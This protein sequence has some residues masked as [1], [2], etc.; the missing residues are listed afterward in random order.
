MSRLKFTKRTLLALPTPAEKRTFHYDTATPG[1]ALQI[2]PKGARTFYLCR[3]VNGR[4]QRL[5]L[6]TFPAVTV[7]QA[8]RLALEALGEIADGKDPHQQRLAARA[9]WTLQDLFDDYLARHAKP[10]K[11][12]WRE[13]ERQFR[14]Y[15]AQWRTRKLSEIR[16][17][18]VK[19]WHLEIGDKAGR[20]AANR[21]LALLRGMFNYAIRE[22]DLPLVNPA[23]GIRPFKEES[24]ERRLM[25]DELPA[26][27]QAVAEE[28]NGTIRDYVLISLL[29]GARRS[30][31]LS[32]RWEEIDLDE[33][34]WQIPGAKT[35]NGLPLNV[36]LARPAVEI[37]L[38]RRETVG[39]SPWVFPS[40]TKTG[41]LSDPKAGWKRI[42]DRAGLEN[43]R[44]HDLRRS[45]ASWQIDTGA[46]LAVVGRTLGHLSPA[47]TRVYARLAQDPVNRAVDTAVDA[48]LA[49]AGL[50]PTAE[51][52]ELPVGK[53]GKASIHRIQERTGT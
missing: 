48:M 21:A 20:Y 34:L 38:A 3:R 36:H 42:L 46:S 24:R 51:V 2:T 40:R 39:D 52:V 11:R 5:R 8:R 7:E 6:G 19:T 35:K 18:H 16:K 22:R 26:F 31:V 1:L 53:G 37:L 17:A 41:H 28:P 50:Q 44:L 33:D 45:L 32:M 25:P 30:N 15:L 23:V 29:T 10:H 47:A 14:R 43:L 12:T 9:E 27:F 49:A 13:D 4:F